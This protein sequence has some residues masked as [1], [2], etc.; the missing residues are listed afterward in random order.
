MSGDTEGS[1]VGTKPSTRTVTVAP[2]EDR[3]GPTGLV[4]KVEIAQVEVPKSNLGVDMR[5]QYGRSSIDGTADAGVAEFT[6]LDDS[7]FTWR[8]HVEV[9]QLV[10][11]WGGSY[12]QFRGEISD[13]ALTTDDMTGGATI[14][15]TATGPL[16]KAGRTVLPTTSYPEETVRARLGR[17]E[18]DS[19]L[20]IQVL[21]TGDGPTVT[22]GDDT[23]L[24]VYSMLEQLALDAGAVVFDHPGGAYLG[25]YNLPPRI[26]FQTIEYRANYPIYEL[27]P[28]R[29]LLAPSWSRTLSIANRVVVAWR[30]PTSDPDNP[31]EEKSI[32]VSDAGSISKYGRWDEL[33]Q[34]SVTSSAAATAR[35][36]ERLARRGRPYWLVDEA[37]YMRT[38]WSTI[39]I[40]QRV[41]IDPLPAGSPRRS[42]APVI[43]GYVHI[44]D[45][46]GVTTT[47]TLSDPR[48]SYLSDKWEQSGSRTWATIKPTIAWI[49]LVDIHDLDP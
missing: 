31:Y 40:G 45:A 35:G 22:A 28:F 18:A 8:K 43:E 16:A 44:V 48:A 15:I 27:D 5:V 9:G 33:I 30:Q 10:E 2:R 47:L 21:M 7:S 4:N 42:W 25:M 37:S 19:G 17:L 11:I 24:S 36:N 46:T 20:T 41:G 32:T 6:I 26:V 34:T 13:I 3:K 12:P 29:V 49:E 38:Y 14:T 39:D 23:T 1:S